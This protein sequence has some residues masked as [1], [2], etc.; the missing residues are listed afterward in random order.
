[1]GDSLFPIA[2]YLKVLLLPKL[3]HTPN[4]LSLNI[5]LHIPLIIRL[6]RYN[7]L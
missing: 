2:D 6:A 3:T 7:T 4:E 1:M 5:Y